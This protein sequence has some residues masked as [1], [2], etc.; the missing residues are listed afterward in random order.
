MSPYD[1]AIQS[2]TL[3]RP[4]AMIMHTHAL[5]IRFPP[6]PG[7]LVTNLLCTYENAF[8]AYYACPFIYAHCTD[9]RTGT[10]IS[11]HVFYRNFSSYLRSSAH[12]E[13]LSFHVL[14]VEDLQYYLFPC[15]LLHLR[16]LIAFVEDSSI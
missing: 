15:L 1:S 4:L 12:A 3:T 11:P 2:F 14:R 5:F 16:A 9:K 7:R 8:P 6:A 13:M 10:R